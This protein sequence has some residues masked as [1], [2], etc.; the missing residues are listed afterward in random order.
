MT[1]KG[2]NQK[3]LSICTLT[4]CNG[5]K[6][7]HIS[8]LSSQN[9]AFVCYLT[10]LFLG[11]C[12]HTACFI[13]NKSYINECFLIT[14]YEI[15]NNSKTNVKNFQVF[16]SK[17]SIF[18]YKEH[19]NKFDA[20]VDEAI[21]LGYSLTLKSYRVLNKKSRILKKAN[22]LHLMTNSLNLFIRSDSMWRYFHHHVPKH[23]KLRRLMTISLDSLTDQ[24]F[25]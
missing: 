25:L 1:N 9:N 23:L 13:Q 20:K 6:A 17:C 10:S 18:N 21:F 11:I 15:L 2:I 24:N 3:F 4:E 19:C 7:K 5:W 14:P 12:Y 8:L 16:G 22:M